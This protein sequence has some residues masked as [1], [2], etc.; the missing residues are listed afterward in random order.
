MF[1]F[2]TRSVEVQFLNSYHVSDASLGFAAGVMIAASFWSLLAPAIDIAEAMAGR[3][4]FIHSTD[5][6]CRCQWLSVTG[7]I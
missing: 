5:P 6:Y 4:L 1:V 2:F 7:S 3:L